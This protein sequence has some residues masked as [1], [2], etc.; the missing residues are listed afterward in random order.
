MD[1]N[2]NV[3][4]EQAG[5]FIS[6]VIVA[7]VLVFGSTTSDSRKED[8]TSDEEAYS[9]DLVDSE[10]WEESSSQSSSFE[11]SSSLESS[12]ITWS[13]SSVSEYKETREE[14]IY[15]AGY[16]H[17]QE[18]AYEESRERAEMRSI[19]EE[20]DSISES[21]RASSIE[22]KKNSGFW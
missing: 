14:S 3:V 9:S 10:W 2:S 21:K 7:L 1:D 11:S 6:I 18:K 4:M 16:A 12:E 8:T 15:N 22:A 13:S 5:C 20:E 17:G 19:D